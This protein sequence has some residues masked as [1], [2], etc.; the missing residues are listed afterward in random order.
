MALKPGLTDV[1]GLK[2]SPKEVGVFIYKNK[3]QTK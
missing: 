1:P 3:I 2:K